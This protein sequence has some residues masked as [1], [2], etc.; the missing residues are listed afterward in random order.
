VQNLGALRKLMLKRVIT[1]TKRAFGLKPP[2]RNLTVFPDDTFLV[3]YPKSGN[4]WARFLIANLLRPD[5]K[6]GFSNIHALIPGIDVVPHR[7]MLR[8]PRPRIIKSH[9]YFDLRYRRVIYIVRDP[10]DVA[11]S[12]YH[13]QRKSKRIGDDSPIEEFVRRFV[14]GESCDYGS[15]GEHAASW[16]ATRYGQAGFLLVRYEDMIEDTARELARM[17]DFLGQHPNAELIGQAVSRSRADNMRKLEKSQAALFNATKDTRQDILFVRS[18]K[19]GGWRSELPENSILLI[20]QAWG[21]MIRWLG[22]ELVMEGKR[23]VAEPAFPISAGNGP[24]R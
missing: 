2:G 5:E 18:A 12:E 8:V 10:R 20:E 11:L 23:S 16:L 13:A 19:A 4:T 3:S 1:G 22:Y 24:G 6:V 15:W 9:Q 21:H 14:A 7:E 17:A